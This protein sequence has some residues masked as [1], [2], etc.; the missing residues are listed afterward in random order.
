EQGDGNTRIFAVNAAGGAPRA[1]TPAGVRAEIVGLSAGDPTSV[2]IMLN[3]RDPTWPDLFR[4]NIATGERTQLERNPGRA[5]RFVRY[6][7][8]LDGRVRLGLHPTE[9]GG[10]EM[11]ARSPDGRWTSLFVIPPEDAMTA[12]PIAFAADGRSFLMLDS[13]GRDRAALVRVDAMT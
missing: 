3:Q 13:T 9:D 4:V 6:Y 5:C 12:R 1:L 10:G 8:D 7:I 2:L 11:F